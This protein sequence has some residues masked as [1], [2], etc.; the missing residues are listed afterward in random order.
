LWDQKD[1]LRDVDEG[2]FYL[3]DAEEGERETLVTSSIDAEPE[4]CLRVPGPSFL[5]M[6]A[7]VFTGGAFIFPTYHLYAAGLIS[8]AVA[9][10]VI[11]LWLWTGTAVIPEKPD[12]D[13]G[14]GLRLPLYASGP[15]SVG[16]WAMFITML[17]DMTAFLSLVFAHFFCWTVHADFPPATSPGAGLVWPGLGLAL[18]L[19]AWLATFFARGWNR[20]GD[21][22]AMRIALAAA[23][24]LASLGGACLLAG[25]WVNGLDPTAHVYPAMVW[26][27]LIWTA[28]HVG[29]G[30]IMQLY[31]IARSA[32][33]LLTP[34]HD[35][36]LCNVT[37]FWHFVAAT[38]L[39][40][41]AVVALFPGLA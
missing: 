31:C 35:I 36:D 33:G 19:A 13:V 38:T 27:L 2:R 24:A 37:L 25:P 6:I 30:I 5:P 39:I 7:A 22:S 21:V 18:L 10:C 3:P 41:V 32:A 8:G 34:S 17:G 29:A 16:W 28:L 1:F 15:R 26:I 23:V 40:T 20:R 12:K 4:Q 11:L 9:I 14:L